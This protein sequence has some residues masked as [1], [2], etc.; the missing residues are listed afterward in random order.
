MNTPIEFQTL[1][2]ANGQP[3]FAVVPYAE[4]LKLYVKEEGVIPHEVVSAVVDGLS[5]IRAWREYLGLTDAEVA[6]RIQVAPAVLAEW[7][8][9]DARPRKTILR[10]IAAALGLSLEQLDF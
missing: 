9:P 7:E 3:A 2:G 4:F 6:A 5:P 1:L 10:R 8:A